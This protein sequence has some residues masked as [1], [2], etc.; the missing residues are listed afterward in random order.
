M[1]GVGA[2]GNFEEQIG[3]RIEDRGEHFLEIDLFVTRDLGRSLRVDGSAGVI[4]KQECDVVT[5]YID[6]PC[7]IRGEPRFGRGDDGDQEQCVD[8]FDSFVAW[9]YFSPVAS[10][11]AW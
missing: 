11:N 10:S 9:R 2:F 4:S 3:S 8:H 5:F 6:S 7:R 1:V